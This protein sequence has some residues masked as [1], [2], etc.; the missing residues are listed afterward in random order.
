[1]VAPSSEL[2]RWYGHQL[3]CWEQFREKYRVELSNGPQLT[4]V[5]NLIERTRAGRRT[6][7]VGARDAEHNQGTV[8]GAPIIERLE[9]GWSA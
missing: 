2:R 6:L 1:M 3:E 8:L 9:A 7:V 4:E 5:E